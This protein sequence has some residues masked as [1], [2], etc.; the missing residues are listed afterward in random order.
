M[1]SGLRFSGDSK[2]IRKHDIGKNITTLQTQRV[3]AI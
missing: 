1:K 2:M 3:E